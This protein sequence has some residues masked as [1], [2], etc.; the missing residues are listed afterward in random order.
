MF[1]AGSLLAPLIVR[2]FEP[3]TVLAGGFLVTAVGYGVLAQ[4][5][6]V[7]E[8]WIVLTGFMLFCAG[9]APMGTLTTDIVMSAAPPEKAGAAS[10]VSVHEIHASD[11]RSQLS[12]WR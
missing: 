7:G 2:R 9:L 10:G 4:V 5:S 3:R 6:V 1:V 8:L 11:R 12:V